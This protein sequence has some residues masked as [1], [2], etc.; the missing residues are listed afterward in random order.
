MDLLL[1][2]SM[3]SPVDISPQTKRACS[4]E[5]AGGTKM[6]SSPDWLS[7]TR[8]SGFSVSPRPGTPPGLQN[9][10]LRGSPRQGPRHIERG[11]YTRS[12]FQPLLVGDEEERAEALEEILNVLEE[13]LGD[14]EGSRSPT[15][16]LQ[17]HLGTIVLLS[18]ECPFPD[19]RLAFQEFLRLVKDQVRTL[20]SLY[21]Q[22]GETDCL[23]SV[24][25]SY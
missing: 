3:T 18:T 15:G 21:L 22:M 9:T 12:F 8:P 7:K 13:A 19:V 25:G 23:S 2:C 14:E 6:A 1:Q 10:T 4:E 5:K 11:N 20:L 16:L 17:V 24:A